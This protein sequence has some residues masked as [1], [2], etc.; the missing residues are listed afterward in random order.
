MLCAYDVLL[1]RPYSYNHSTITRVSKTVVSII[2]SVVI[3]TVQDNILRLERAAVYTFV[4]YAV[5]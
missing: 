5:S 2:I 3:F 4:I 1:R